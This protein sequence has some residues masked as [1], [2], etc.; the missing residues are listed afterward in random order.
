MFVQFTADQIPP[1]GLATSYYDN[2]QVAQLVQ[3]ANSGTDA[4]QR[5]SDYCAAAKQV[6]NDAPWI[7]LYNQKNPI[8]TTSKV[9]GIYGLPNEQFITTWASPA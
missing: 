7:F 6:W 5:K 8:V 4:S 2:A 1:K 3:K 9:K